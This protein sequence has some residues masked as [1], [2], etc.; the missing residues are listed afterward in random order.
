[1]LGREA[2]GVA[3]DRPNSPPAAGAGGAD[4]SAD[5]GT[6]QS[7]AR[8]AERRG[9][10]IAALYA[11]VSTD[12]QE[13]DET[14]ASQ[15]DA[16]QRAAAAGGYAVAPEHVFVDGHHSGARLNRPALDR[17]RDLAADGTFEAVLVTRPGSVGPAV[18]PSSTADRGIDA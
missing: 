18:C 11:R 14:I 5:P 17:L 7:R 8:G 1:M 3:S 15:L 9:V 2:T 13:K 10:T 12:K 16:L 6:G 4:S